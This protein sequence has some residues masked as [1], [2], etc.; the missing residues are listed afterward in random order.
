MCSNISSII[1]FHKR[2]ITTTTKKLN[3]RQDGIS[4]SSVGV[5]KQKHSKMHDKNAEKLKC[6][7]EFERKK[8]K[9]R[10]KCVQFCMHHKREIKRRA[11][12][13]SFKFR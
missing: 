4:S 6:I 8:K 2:I 11:K 10:D 12:N 9:Q 3:W 7:L 13:I 1:N 5:C